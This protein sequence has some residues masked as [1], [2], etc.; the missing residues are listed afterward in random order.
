MTVEQVVLCGLQ[1]R[2]TAD[3]KSALPGNPSRHRNAGLFSMVPSE[4]NTCLVASFLCGST[5]IR[6]AE[7]VA[8]ELRLL[9]RFQQRKL[10]ITTRPKPETAV[11]GQ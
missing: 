4:Q 5:S 8:E 2:D 7:D 10:G 11:G 1:I 6:F 9:G 3:C